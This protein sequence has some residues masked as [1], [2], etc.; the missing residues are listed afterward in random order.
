VRDVVV[1][2]NGS[3]DRTSERAR[4][5]GARVV[6]EPRRGY[7]AACL[8]GLA[9]LAADTDV[10]VFLDADGSD[11]PTVLPSLVEPI[12]LGSAD[13]VVGTRMRGAIQHGAVTPQQRIGT[14][15][16]AA[17]LRVRFGLPA[18]DLGPFRA[19]RR[20]S[21]EVLR[22]TDRT[23]GWTVEMQIKAARHGLRYT[24]VPVPY[25]R[26]LHGS[27]KVSGTVRGTLGATI[28]ILGLLAWHDLVPMKRT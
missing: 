27:S 24:E 21:L 5:A 16:A 13:L 18:T 11:D 22:M 12:N 17:W 8:A 14:A 23:Y 10:I 26:R 3:A 25:R 2:D 19:I 28:K 4:A 7:G 20:E 6:L 15:V 1:V 9:A